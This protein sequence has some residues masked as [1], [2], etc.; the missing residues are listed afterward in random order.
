[1]SVL[2]LRNTALPAK[3]SKMFSNGGAVEIVAGEHAF[4]KDNYHLGVLHLHAAGVSRSIRLSF[5]IDITGLLIATVEEE[6]TGRVVNR[7]FESFRD[8][9]HVLASVES[10][11]SWN[12]LTALADTS[13]ARHQNDLLVASMANSSGPW[14]ELQHVHAISS[15]QLLLALTCAQ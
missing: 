15:Y 7:S 10:R 14:Y 8:V 4:A 9:Q 1:M 12:V 13:N 5:E 11:G 3:V 6:Q 2:L